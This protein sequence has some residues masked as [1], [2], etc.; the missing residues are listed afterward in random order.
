MVLSQVKGWEGA[1]AVAEEALDGYFVSP[2]YRTFSCV[3]G[4]CIP[5]YLSAIVRTPFFHRMLVDATKGQGARRE[6]T[7]PEMLLP[8]Q[9]RMPTISNQE[10]AIRIL[11]RAGKVLH[12]QQH[13][14]AELDALLPSIL[15]KA[16]KGEL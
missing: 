9:V 13:S 12:I 5:E 3:P 1:V 15:D 14:A 2:E 11:K 6:R 4:K 16:F 8:M 10:R 7:R